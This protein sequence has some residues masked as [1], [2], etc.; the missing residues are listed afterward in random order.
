MDKFETILQ[1]FTIPV[2]LLISASLWLII[3]KTISLIRFLL[4]S[5]E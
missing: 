4:R 3:Y 1:K 5:L 2:V